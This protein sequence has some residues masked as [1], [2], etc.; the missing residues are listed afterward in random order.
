MNACICACACVQGC[1]R[2]L[3]GASFSVCELLTVLHCRFQLPARRVVL[4]KG[5]AAVMQYACLHAR[6]ELSA[7]ALLSYKGGVGC[8]DAHADLVMDT[9]SLGQCL[10][11]VAGG[12]RGAL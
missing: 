1:V 3:Q 6:G 2:S 4:S 11:T 5:H 8:P 12:A 7:P 10:S 9:G